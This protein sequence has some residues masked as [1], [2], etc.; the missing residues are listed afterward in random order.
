MAALVDKIERNGLFTVTRFFALFIILCLTLAFVAMLLVVMK[1]MNPQTSTEV[2]SEEVLSKIRPTAERQEAVDT[3]PEASKRQRELPSSPL[4][5]YR[6]PFQLQEALSDPDASRVVRDHII[7]Y[8]V[9]E[10]QGYLDEMGA[11]VVLAQKEKLDTVRTINTFMKLKDEKL[12]EKNRKSDEAKE[13]RL[14][15]MAALGSALALIAMFSLV[16]VLLA[17]ERNTR[18]TTP[19]PAVERDTRLATA[20]RS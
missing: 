17:I 11:V 5:G 9:D 12:D 14:Y 6:I 16:L 4:A 2:Q 1:A 13:Q 10:R 20:S 15:G 3:T 19:H 8:P 7:R 18:P